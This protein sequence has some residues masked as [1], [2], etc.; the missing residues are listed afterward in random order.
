[1]VQQEQ[2]QPVELEEDTANRTI[3]KY[4][5]NFAVFQPL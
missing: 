3:I 2:E 5:G 1:M 4:F